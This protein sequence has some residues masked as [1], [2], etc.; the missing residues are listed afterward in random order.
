[1]RRALLSPSVVAVEAAGGGRQ[2]CAPFWPPWAGHTRPRPGSG[3]PCLLRRGAHP[4]RNGLRSRAEV[5]EKFQKRRPRID[6]RRFEDMTPPLPA[7]QCGDEWELEH[8]GSRH[9]WRGC[10]W[11]D[12]G[13]GFGL[14]GLGVWSASTKGEHPEEPNHRAQDQDQH[15]QKKDNFKKGNEIVPFCRNLWPCINA[16]TAKIKAFEQLAMVEL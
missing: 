4:S 3:P 9:H 13:V 8:D 14:L 12:L 6:G 15:T 7:S 11:W 10:I 5:K 1:V 2:V 16:D